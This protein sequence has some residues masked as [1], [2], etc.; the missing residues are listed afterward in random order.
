MDWNLLPLNETSEDA[1]ATGL[2]I[3]K[4]VGF[5]SLKKYAALLSQDFPFVR[6]D[7]YLVNDKPMFGELTFTPAAGLDRTD[8]KANILLGKMLNLSD[9]GK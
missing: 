2:E 9:S 4:P 1:I 6:A 5:E 3:E 7:F 8:V